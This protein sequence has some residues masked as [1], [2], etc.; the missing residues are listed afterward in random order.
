VKAA[1]IKMG[2]YLN[3]IILVSLMCMLAVTQNLWLLNIPIP[4][5][6]QSVT[7]YCILLNNARIGMKKV[8]FQKLKNFRVINL[9][10]I[11]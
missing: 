6:W 11:L 3:A 1:A 2:L 5:R 10:F 4:T 8:S 9:F 7:R